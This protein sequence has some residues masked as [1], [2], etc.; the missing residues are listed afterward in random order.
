MHRRDLF[1]GLPALALAGLAS[2]RLRAAPKPVV[3][4]GFCVMLDPGHGGDNHG[5]SAHDGAVLEKQL[6]LAIA[7]ELSERLTELMPHAVVLT[8]RSGDETLHLSQ[9]VAAANAAAADLLVSLHCNASPRGDQTGFE[10]FVLDR[11]ASCEQ[12]ALTAQRENDEGFVAPR[13]RDDDEVAAMV[14]EL[15]LSEN[16]RRSAWLAHA[17]QREQARR[18]PARPDRGVRQAPFDVLMGARMPAVLH[19]L[20][21][22]DHPDDGALL[23]SGGSRTTMVEGLARAVLTYFNEVAR[24]D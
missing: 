19:E 16:R 14:R 7:A 1:L 13:S 10:T 20:A 9:R 6:T 11:R 23:R 3:D 4:Q 24:R 18:F 8:T 21:F 15:E 2:P 17:I 12:A 5:C 22:L